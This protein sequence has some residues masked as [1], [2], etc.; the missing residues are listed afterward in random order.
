MDLGL[1]QADL[2]ERFGVD[3]ATVYRW[4]AGRKGIGPQH[5]PAV[6]EFI[7]CDPREVGNGF[8]EQVRARRRALGLTQEALA[9]KLGL[10][11]STV[12]KVEAQ[13]PCGRKA[14]GV[15]EAFLEETG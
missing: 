11:H 9:A 15:L 5:L 13:R 12:W 3:E 6:I 8:G 4:E 2:G 7:G 14:R 1:L 10:S